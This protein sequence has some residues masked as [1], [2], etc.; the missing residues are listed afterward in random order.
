ML[1]LF[2]WLYNQ[3]AG[4]VHISFNTLYNI[5]SP[6][7][8]N[9]GCDCYTDSW[10][11]VFISLG[12]AFTHCDK[13]IYIYIYTLHHIFF[14]SLPP[15]GCSSYLKNI[16]LKFI[17]EVHIVDNVQMFFYWLSNSIYNQI[18]PCIHYHLSWRQLCRY[19]QSESRYSNQRT[20]GMVSQAICIWLK[21]IWY[22]FSKGC[23][24][25][26][27]EWRYMIHRYLDAHLPDRMFVKQVRRT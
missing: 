10:K 3:F 4:T 25:R 19:V 27:L 17:L 5:T 11:V 6:T 24:I 2:E 1:P 23:N 26:D 9:R 18:I 13:D 12:I 7:K 22:I 8:Q 15:W 14:N 20:N 21:H 16:M